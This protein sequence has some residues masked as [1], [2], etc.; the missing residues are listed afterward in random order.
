MADVVHEATVGM[1]VLS[2]VGCCTLALIGWLNGC[3]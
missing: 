2:A 1:L 3:F